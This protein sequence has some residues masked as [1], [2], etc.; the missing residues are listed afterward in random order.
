M[1]KRLVLLGVLLCF[2]SVDVFAQGA[3]RRQV[4][5][6]AT[7]VNDFFTTPAG[8]SLGVVILGATVLN[9][10]NITGLGLD[11]HTVQSDA[12]PPLVREAHADAKATSI[13]ETKW[14]V[15]GIEMGYYHGTGV[16]RDN[17][18][19]E[20]EL[21]ISFVTTIKGNDISEEDIWLTVS[22]GEKEL[23]MHKTIV[24]GDTDL[25]FWT[26]DGWPA[27]VEAYIS[28]DDYDEPPAKTTYTFIP[29][30]LVK[31]VRLTKDG[32]TTALSGKIL[33]GDDR[34]VQWDNVELTTLT[35]IRGGSHP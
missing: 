9:T 30:G 28:P 10:I 16:W 15:W 19:N 25:K 23:K 34:T 2:V 32:K 1:M 7:H 17:Q 4:E 24:Y 8:V 3:L 20:G 5:R 29:D 11:K 31:L 33:E 13:T 27:D 18:G 14:P 6:M 22:Y 12:P 26:L 21:K 35:F